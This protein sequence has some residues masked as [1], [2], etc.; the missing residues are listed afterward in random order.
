[1]LSEE[2]LQWKLQPLS[3]YKDSYVDYEK[4]AIRKIDTNNIDTS[5]H[6]LVCTVLLKSSNCSVNVVV[7]KRGAN[8]NAP[9][10]AGETFIWLYILI[11]MEIRV[12]KVS[13][14]S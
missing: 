1:M 3:F 13:K 6:N 10:A 14:I 12:L 9:S 5:I 2:G 8:Y 7:I 11:N 4:H